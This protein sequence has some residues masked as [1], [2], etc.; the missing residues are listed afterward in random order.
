MTKLHEFVPYVIS[1]ERRNHTRISTKIVNL[2]YG[3]SREDLL[4]LFAIARVT[5]RRNDKN[6]I[7]TS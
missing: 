1:T 3:V 4:R 7:N 6:A 2:L 5:S